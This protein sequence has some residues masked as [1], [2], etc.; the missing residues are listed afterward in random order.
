MWLLSGSVKAEFGNAVRRFENPF[1]I[2]N[3]AIRVKAYTYY[4]PWRSW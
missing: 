3:A 1:A 2:A 4:K